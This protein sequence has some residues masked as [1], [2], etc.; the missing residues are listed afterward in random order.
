LF[1]QLLGFW[2][3][4]SGIPFLKGIE[5]PGSIDLLKVMLNSQYTAYM[6]CLQMDRVLLNRFELKQMGMPF[7]LVR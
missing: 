6:A 7:E 1:I 4:F 3:R 2:Q 5:V